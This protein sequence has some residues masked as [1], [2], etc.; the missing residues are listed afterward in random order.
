MRPDA[1]C[2]FSVRMN[3]SATPLVSGSRTKAKLGTMPKNFSCF[4]KCSDMK[5]LPWSWRN[6]TPR[7]ASARTEPKTWLTANSRLHTAVFARRLSCDVGALPRRRLHLQHGDRQAGDVN[8]GTGG[9]DA[10]PPFPS[11]R[12]GA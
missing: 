5:G 9:L 2:S 11:G 4:W 7:A 3:R 8:G 10:R 12:K 1:I 6:D